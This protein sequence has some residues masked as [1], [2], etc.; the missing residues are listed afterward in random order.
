VE[1]AAWA[2]RGDGPAQYGMPTPVDCLFPPESRNYIVR[3]CHHTRTIAYLLYSQKPE[4]PF[5]SEFIIAVLTPYLKACQGSCIDF[6][7][8]VGA[9]GMASAAVS[10]S[11]F[12]FVHST[13]QYPTG[14]T[15]VLTFHYRHTC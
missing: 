5:Q 1:F 7:H 3:I 9:L 12:I 13:N 4:G 8:P 2:T 15:R 11:L 14:R 6:G 10:V